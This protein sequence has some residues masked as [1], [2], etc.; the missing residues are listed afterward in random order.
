LRFSPGIVLE[1]APEIGGFCRS[2]Y[3]TWD[4]LAESARLTCPQLEISQ[5]LWG[6]A[7]QA[8]GRHGATLA[9]AVTIHQSGRQQIRSPGGYFHAMIARAEKG[10]LDLKRSYYGMRARLAPPEPTKGPG[11][12]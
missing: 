3:P 2:A 6:R 1:A 10:E 7:C 9:L 11:P 5:R 4:E 8:L 12:H